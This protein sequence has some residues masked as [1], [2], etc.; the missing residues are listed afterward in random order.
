MNTSRRSFSS[1]LALTLASTWIAF[2]G[3][4]KTGDAFPD[5][6][7]SNLEG[8]LPDLA[9]KV[10][11]VDFWASWCGPCKKALPVLA[12]LH[13]EYGSKGVVVVAVSL[14]EEKA[15]METFLRKNPLPFTVVRDPK[16][17]LAEQLGIQGIPVSF[18]LSK[19]GKVHAMH[20]GFEGDK[21]RTRYVAEI[22]KLLK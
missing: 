21:T 14:D 13:K 19:D 12:D 10:V 8:T 18:V 6:S 2:A 20:E 5:L 3:T 9:G 4:P 7:K 16:G 11:I 22:E 15:D 17:K 1:L